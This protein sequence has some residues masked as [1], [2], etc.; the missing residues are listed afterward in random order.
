MT[1]PRGGRTGWDGSCRRAA[2]KHVGAS[3][4]TGDGERVM[5]TA[6]VADPRLETRAVAR[7]AV[8]PMAVQ[9]TVGRSGQAGRGARG[10]ESRRQDERLAG[11][12]DPRRW[13]RALLY[14]RSCAWPW[15][16]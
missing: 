1:G 2:I 14:G 3:A 8:W 5:Q 15:A 11:R 4:M 6:P 13:G 10:D 16:A 7:S 12:A 9:G